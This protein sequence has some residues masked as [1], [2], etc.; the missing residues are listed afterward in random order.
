[1]NIKNQFKAMILL[2]S[3][4]LFPGSIFA[5]GTYAKGSVVAKIIQFESRGIL[6]DSYEGVLEITGLDKDEKCDEAKDECFTP[7]TQKM[8]FSVRPE[9]ADLVNYL[10]KNLNQELLLQYRVH[11]IKA[12]ALSSDMEILSAA[13]QEA[14]VPA[15]QGDKLIVAKSGSKRNFSVS[16]KVLQLDYQGTFI[17][18]YEGLYVDAIR[19]KV[20]PFSVTSE[21]MAKYAQV[22]MKSSTKY[23][24]G[25]SVAYATG[26]RKSNY[27]LFEINYK[28]PA[29]G[30]HTSMNEPSE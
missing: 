12:I 9:N 11:R 29:G 27:D 19:G 4:S 22:S 24:M 16:G 2:L 14:S 23:N 25:I 28:E 10:Q 8:D 26:F 13:K 1:M 20:H 15:E 18:T 21:Q 5:F 7:V 30:V 17:G 6:F 3:V